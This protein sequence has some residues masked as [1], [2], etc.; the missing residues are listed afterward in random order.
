[1]QKRLL[2]IENQE[3]ARSR[4]I[5]MSEKTPPQPRHP[6]LPKSSDSGEPLFLLT[7]PRLICDTS[8]KITDF[9]ECTGIDPFSNSL[10]VFCTRDLKL[11][12]YVL[13]LVDGALNLEFIPLGF[14]CLL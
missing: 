2:D 9:V 4:S 14:L 10:D 11:K 3:L 8:T 1:M 7:F 12:L 5:P 6:K 13:I